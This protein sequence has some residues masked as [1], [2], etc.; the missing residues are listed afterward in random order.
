MAALARYGELQTR[1]RRSNDLEETVRRLAMDTPH[2]ETDGAS[3][4]TPDIY[5]VL[6]NSEASPP[7]CATGPNSP[8]ATAAESA[9]QAAVKRAS[10]AAPCGAHANSGLSKI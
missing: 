7:R 8:L 4:P 2:V 3:L 6:A 10:V 9:Y 5:R 1:V